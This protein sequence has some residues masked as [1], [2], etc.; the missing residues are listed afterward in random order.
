MHGPLNVKRIYICRK[1]PVNVLNIHTAIARKAPNGSGSSW[2]IC[3][4]G[5]DAKVLV[6]TDIVLVLYLV[7]FV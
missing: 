4:L 3:E 5:D 7:P 2:S 6:M 1:S